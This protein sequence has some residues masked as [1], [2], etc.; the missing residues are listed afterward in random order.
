[1]REAPGR[2]RRNYLL[3]DKLNRGAGGIN[4]G[5][6]LRIVGPSYGFFGFGTQKHRTLVLQENPQGTTEPVFFVGH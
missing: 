3:A 6:Y 4:I 1:M 5:A 2:R